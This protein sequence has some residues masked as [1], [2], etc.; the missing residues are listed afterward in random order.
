MPVD[1]DSEAPRDVARTAALR[2]LQHALLTAD[3][4]ALGA[5]DLRHGAADEVVGLGVLEVSEAAAARLAGAAIAALPDAARALVSA[6]DLQVDRAA[7][8]IPLAAR[9]R[10][11]LGS[12]HLIGCRQG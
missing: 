8:R 3:P 10:A 7:R 2:S 9:C 5:A 1:V 6:A 4:D 12:L 11:E